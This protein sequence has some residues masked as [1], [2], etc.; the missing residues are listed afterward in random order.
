MYPALSRRG[1]TGA[2]MLDLIV[3]ALL[4]GSAAVVVAALAMIFGPKIMHQWTTDLSVPLLYVFTLTPAIRQALSPPAVIATDHRGG[5]HYVTPPPTGLGLIVG[6]ATTLAVLAI[7]AWILL[8]RRDPESEQQQARRSRVLVSAAVTFVVVRIAA[9]VFGT[10]GGF[11]D[12][13][14]QLAVDLLVV[15]ALTRRRWRWN[16]LATHASR[17]FRIYAYGSL[18][19]LTVASDRVTTSINQRVLFGVDQLSGLTPHP[20]VLGPLAAVSLLFEL[21]R[22]PPGSPRVSA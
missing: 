7:A 21:I 10:G 16:E 20:N 22:G 5:I 6:Q 14:V 11:S 18:L 12:V 15:L 4:A 3:E 17:I 8:V 9:S 13:I 1:F 19:V 2:Q